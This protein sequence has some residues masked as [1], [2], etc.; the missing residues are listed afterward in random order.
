MPLTR[1]FG[2]IC[3][4]V[5]PVPGSGVCLCRNTWGVLGVLYNIIPFPTSSVSSV[6]F[7]HIS[8]NSS[9]G[10]G[11]NFIPDRTHPYLTEYNIGILH[12]ALQMETSHYVLFNK[13]AYTSHLK[14]IRARAFNTIENPTKLGHTFWEENYMGLAKKRVTS[15]VCGTPRP[16]VLLKLGMWSSLKELS[17]SFLNRRNPLLWK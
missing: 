9:V 12:L 13:D 4:K 7:S 14:I 6:R 1:Q 3:P 10:F 11:I 17:T 15:I 16:Y 5:V 2:K 8:L